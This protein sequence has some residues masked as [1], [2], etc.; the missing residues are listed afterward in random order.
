MIE[1]SKRVVRRIQAFSFQKAARL[2]SEMPLA[3][4]L[5][6]PWDRTP[7][8]LTQN[9][10]NWFHHLHSFETAMPGMASWRRT[11]DAPRPPNGG[12]TLRDRRPLARTDATSN[13]S[14]EQVGGFRPGGSFCHQR[15]G[16]NDRPPCSEA[17]VE[18][19][20]NFLTKGSK[21]T[22]LP[23]ASFGWPAAPVWYQAGTWLAGSLE[24]ADVRAGNMDSG[25]E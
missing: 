13:S 17:F 11:L 7:T 2:R 24:S 22:L 20:A 14:A 5:N 9:P 15:G 1:I 8:T 10:W 21:K 16:Q 18:G 12:R 19:V 6:S 25:W 4:S 3:T 23:T